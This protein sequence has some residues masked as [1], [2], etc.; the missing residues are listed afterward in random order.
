MLND[1]STQTIVG[2]AEGQGLLLVL[3]QWGAGCIEFA[4]NAQASHIH[5]NVQLPQSVR[6]PVTLSGGGSGVTIIGASDDRFGDVVIKHGSSKD[7]AELFALATVAEE[8]RRRENNL[9]V[10]SDPSVRLAAADMRSRLPTFRYVY[11]SPKHLRE[12]SR[13]AKPRGDKFRYQSAWLNR[14]QTKMVS[15]Q[16]DGKATKTTLI[17]R[18]SMALPDLGLSTLLGGLIEKKRAASGATYLGLGLTDSEGD[19]VEMAKNFNREPPQVV[20]A[21]RDLRLRSRKDGED[22]EDCIEITDDMFTVVVDLEINRKCDDPRN[23]FKTKP[24]AGFDYFQ[25]LMGELTREQEK[26]MWKFTLAQARIGGAKQVTASSILAKGNLHGDTLKTLIDEFMLVIRNLQCLTWPQEMQ[27]VDEVRKELS[28]VRDQAEPPQPSDISKLADSFVGFAIKKNFDRQNGRFRKLRGMGYLFRS[29]SLV[30]AEA[31]ACPARLLG[32]LLKSGSRMEQVFAEGPTGLTAFDRYS[33]S[34]LDL[35]ELAVNLPSSCT[36]CIWTCG[37]T[38]SGLH[39][40]FLDSERIWL[41]DLGEPSLMPLPA[42]L[43]KFLM[44]FFHTLGME[45]ADDGGW[46]NRFELTADDKLRPT[47]ETAALLDNACEAFRQTLQRFVVDVFGS[48]PYVCDLLV[49]Y[50]VLQLLSDAAFCLNVWEVKGGGIDRTR[51][52]PLQKWLWRTLWDLYVSSLVANKDWCI[53]IGCRSPSLVSSMWQQLTV[54]SAGAMDCSC[55]S[56]LG[57][58]SKLIAR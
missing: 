17:R 27:A 50:T 30:H 53:E 42:F 40:L 37:L 52:V 32:T 7:T 57:K 41:F 33:S 26:N 51:D 49:R 47:S 35:L 18:G 23:L 29:G 3:D 19:L 4:E 28:A 5:P 43:T 13:V 15:G 16:R 45:D 2:A 24:G 10:E 48:D 46:V 39:N 1:G 14:A 34:W 36:A 6:S 8:L 31:E 9:S 11:I 54:P 20:R 55:W 56:S 21:G 25:R 22:A 38:D 58:A 44:S 12:V